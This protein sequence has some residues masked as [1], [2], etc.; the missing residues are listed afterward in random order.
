MS[1]SILVVE[2]D[3]EIANILDY[4]LKYEGYDITMISDGREAYNLVTKEPEGAETP[5]P[6]V[7][8]LDIMLPHVDGIQIC[9]AIKGSERWKDVP[10]IMLT[11][12]TQEF[13][14]S[15][16]A[17]AGADDYIMKPFSPQDVLTRIRAVREKNAAAE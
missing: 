2:D 16:A 1:A 4:L 6:D 14:V 13:T 8:L 15:F 10:V 11:A 5:L 9:A 7:V 17:R 12:K 3:P